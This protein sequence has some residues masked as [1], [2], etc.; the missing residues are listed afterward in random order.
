MNP[1]FDVL[2]KSYSQ[3]GWD[4]KAARG[5]LSLVAGL[6][7][8]FREPVTL[9][10]AKS[11]SAWWV[12]ISVIFRPAFVSMD[13]KK[14]LEKLAAEG[15]YLTQ[16]EFKGKNEVVRGAKSFAVAPDRSLQSSKRCSQQPF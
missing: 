8:F 2:R 10:K 3:L 6:R 12:A 11:C 4:L 15:V 9:E 1:S 14:T 13:W 7:E 5:M 16:D